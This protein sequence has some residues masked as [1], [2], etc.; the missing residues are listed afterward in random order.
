MLKIICCPTIFI[1]PTCLTKLKRNIILVAKQ[2]FLYINYFW[3]KKTSYIYIYLVKSLMV[4]LQS[5]VILFNVQLFQ[6]YYLE[7]N[8]VTNLVVA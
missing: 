2:K 4:Q 7:K 8:L 6:S 1:F 3:E 5:L